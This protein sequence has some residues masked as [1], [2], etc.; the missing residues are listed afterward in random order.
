MFAFELFNRQKIRLTTVLWNSVGDARQQQQQ[1]SITRH[2]NNDP[3]R[4]TDIN[5]LTQRIVDGIRADRS[6]IHINKQ[7]TFIENMCK[8]FQ[9]EKITN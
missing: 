9:K 2:N 1:Q 8:Y 3:D 6:V 4:A 7:T 5:K